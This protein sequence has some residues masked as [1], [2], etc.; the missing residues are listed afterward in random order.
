V[1]A[2][3]HAID[4][5]IIEELKE[6]ARHRQNAIEELER[7]ASNR[8]QG[9][10]AAAEAL[11]RSA[12]RENARAREIEAEIRGKERAKKKVEQFK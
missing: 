1:H 10:T 6:A 5:D 11:T 4:D 2:A 7:A 9:N 8:E 3:I 12:A